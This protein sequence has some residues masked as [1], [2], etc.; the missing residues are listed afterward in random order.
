V[1]AAPLALAA[2]AG[3]SGGSSGPVP[4][5]PPAAAAAAPG[6]ATLH[7]ALPTTLDGRA[8]RVTTP[9]STSTAAWGDPALVLRCGVRRPAALRLTSELIVVDHVAWLPEDRPQWYVFT[10]VGRTAYV[11]LLVPRSLPREDST[12][13]LPGLA[14]AV[15]SS[16]PRAH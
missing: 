13:A 11:E 15:S 8:S 5:T 16:V 9:R 1:V 12:A 6:C 10:T 3:C 2:L 4:V 7:G 14:A